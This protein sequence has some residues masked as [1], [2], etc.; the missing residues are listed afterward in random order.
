MESP[1]EELTA[2]FRSVSYQLSDALRSSITPPMDSSNLD[3]IQSLSEVE[4]PNLVT[5]TSNYRVSPSPSTRRRLQLLQEEPDE[6]SDFESDDEAF[7]MSTPSLASSRSCRSSS[8]GVMIEDQLDVSP[9]FTKEVKIVGFHSVGR[10]AGGFVVYDISVH[11][12]NGSF[13][14]SLKRYSAFVKL[15]SNLIRAFPHRRSSLPALPPKS[16]VAKFRPDFLVRRQKGLEY[17]LR[18]VLLNSETGSCPL[19]KVWCLE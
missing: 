7:I 5:V 11:L 3:P 8:L 16:S 6:D 18:C 9:T 14:R 10:K 12:S 15:R 17:F 19:V 4:A 13:I 1:E 2:S